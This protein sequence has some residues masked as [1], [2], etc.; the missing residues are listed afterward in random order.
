MIIPSIRIVILNMEL[1]FEIVLSLFKKFKLN[2][3]KYPIVQYFCQVKKRFDIQNHF[4]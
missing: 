3:S 1:N 2:K 4:L